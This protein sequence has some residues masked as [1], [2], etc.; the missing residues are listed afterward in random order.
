MFD[1]F[2][3]FCAESCAKSSHEK[4]KWKRQRR[5][6]QRFDFGSRVFYFLFTLDNLCRRFLT[7][8]GLLFM[9]VKGLGEWLSSQK[10]RNSSS[11]RIWRWRSWPPCPLST[12]F[13]SASCGCWMGTL[14]PLLPGKKKTTPPPPQTNT[15]SVAPTGWTYALNTHFMPASRFSC[16]L[17]NCVQLHALS[18][19]A[20][21]CID[22]V[23]KFLQ[24][25]FFLRPIKL[26]FVNS[27]TSKR[28]KKIDQLN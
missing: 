26:L 7:A 14:S 10:R 12:G 2:A 20:V 24:P 18:D 8:P 9:R 11:R 3:D 22:W 17:P 4:P 1:V 25:R 27:T 16:I 15:S 23:S 6:Q 13:C 28:S 21:V 19:V 5:Q